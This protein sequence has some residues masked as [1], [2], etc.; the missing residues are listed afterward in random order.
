MNKL[1]RTIRHLCMTPWRV[2]R[3]F[4]DDAMNAIEAV[5]EQSERAHTGQ[6]RVVVEAALPVELLWRSLPA[7][8]RA[9]DVFSSL[10]IWDTEHNNGVLLYL[11]LADHDVEIVA[12]R[13]IARRVPQEEW[14]T[15]CR[16]MEAAF[17]AGDFKNGVLAGIQAVADKLSTH[18]PR[19]EGGANELPNRP[20]VL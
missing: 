20:L 9:I 6:I 14:E 7:R 13:G 12:D 8:E 5:V 19:L 4:P 16:Q 10:R 3:T 2:S 18:F 17:R 1:T 15:I 11:L